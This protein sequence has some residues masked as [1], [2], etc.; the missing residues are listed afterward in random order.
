[1]LGTKDA[2]F[3]LVQIHFSTYHGK[4]ARQGNFHLICTS[5][6]LYAVSL[7]CNY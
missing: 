2:R 1:M 6:L 4:L 3:F 7:E 5:S